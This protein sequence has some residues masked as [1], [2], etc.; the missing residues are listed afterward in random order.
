MHVARGRAGVTVVVDG[1]ELAVLVVEDTVKPTSAEAV[2][3]L[4]ALGLTPL[5][6]SGDM[7]ATASTTS[8]SWP[9]PISV[10]PS[11]ATPT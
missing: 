7:E 6:L 2:A 10:W 11:A 8:R 1:R 5:L 3:E 4:K 9:K